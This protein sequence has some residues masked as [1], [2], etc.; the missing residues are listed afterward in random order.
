MY[1]VP[2]YAADAV[3]ANVFINNC[4]IIPNSTY[5]VYVCFLV[6]FPFFFLPYKLRVLFFSL[7]EFR[8]TVF[9]RRDVV[10]CCRTI[11]PRPPSLAIADD[12]IINIPIS[13]ICTNMIHVVNSMRSVH[14]L[15]IRILQHCPDRMSK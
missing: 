4:C 8:F 1:Y 5:F 15:Y 11:G 2:L 14:L 3:K 9:K 6:F 7:S 12:L 10:V 13:Y